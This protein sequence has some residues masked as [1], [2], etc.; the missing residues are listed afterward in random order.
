MN[1]KSLELSLAIKV[2]KKAGNV[3][4]KNFKKKYDK[5]IEKKV[6]K[7]ILKMISE[8]FPNHQVLSENSGLIYKKKD[9]KNI[10][11]V[12][13]LDGTDN[14]IRKVPYFAISLALKRDNNI[15][16]GVIFNPLTN[17]IFYAQ[18]GKGAYLNKKKISVSSIKK[19]EDALISTHGPFQKN[20]NKK[21]ILNQYALA[22]NKFKKPI[23]KFGSPAIDLAFLACG[24]IDAYW[25]HKINVWDV[26]A[27]LIILEEAGGHYKLKKLKEINNTKVSLVASNKH[28]FQKIKRL[29][30]I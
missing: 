23:R 22:S 15:I 17:E 2:C 13:S 26:A 12:D 16:L 1:N 5:K 20:K 9:P 30:K 4:K 24:K 7:I 11:I 29:F 6:E 25:V 28:L 10:W 14:F 19:Y 18:I 21:A 8:T 27:G 3:L